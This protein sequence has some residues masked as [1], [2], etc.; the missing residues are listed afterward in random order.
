M[1][2]MSNFAENLSALMSEQNLKAPALAK[3]LKT[4]RSNI[5][6]YLRGERLPL[7]NG[8]IALITY[9]NVSADVILGRSDYAT[10]TQ[11]LPVPPFGQQLRKVMEETK[12]TQYRIEHDANVSGGSM[13]KWLKNQSVPTV[14]TLVKLANYMDISVDYLL[15]RIQ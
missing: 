10:E 7:F 13:Y 2:I 9:F 11:F 1:D 4:D 14:E 5:T 3:I 6:R 8:F 15:G 12:T